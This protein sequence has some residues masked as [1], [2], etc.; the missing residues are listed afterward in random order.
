MV[1][2]VEPRLDAEQDYVGD[3]SFRLD[4]LSFESS[5]V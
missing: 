4:D 3:L 2:S 5:W 1:E